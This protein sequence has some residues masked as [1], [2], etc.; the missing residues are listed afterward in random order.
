M[1]TRPTARLNRHQ[2]IAAIA[3]ASALGALSALGGTYAAFTAQASTPAQTIQSGTVVVAFQGGTFGT[4][5]TNTSPG[6]VTERNIVL[7]NTGTIAFKTVTLKHLTTGT[8]SLLTTDPLGYS[9]AVWDAKATPADTSDDTVVLAEQKF[10]TFIGPLALTLSNAQK[11]A[12]ATTNL[13]LVYTFDAAAPDT[14]QGLSDLVTFTVDAT[15]RDADV[16]VETSPT[17]TFNG[18]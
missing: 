2:K 8:H 12:G 13:R 6:D 7:A 10:N 14:F 18:R 3:A 4:P 15:Q 11:A 9:V 16:F 17:G 5:I 1:P